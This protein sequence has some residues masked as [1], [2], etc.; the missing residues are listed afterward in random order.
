MPGE[1]TVRRAAVS[2][3]RPLQGRSWSLVPE[4]LCALPLCLASH[5]VLATVSF[6]F[7]YIFSLRPCLRTLFP[8]SHPNQRCNP[9]DPA[10]NLSL[11]SALCSLP[12]RLLLWQELPTHLLH[13]G[14]PSSHQGL[15]ALQGMSLRAVAPWLK[16]TI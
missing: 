1:G 9:P 12:L 11:G 16:H 13:L 4:A 14:N 3:A 10:A 7:R 15:C 2:G 8:L 6:G 5:L